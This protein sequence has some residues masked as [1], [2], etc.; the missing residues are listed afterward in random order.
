M[1][2]IARVLFAVWVYVIIT[3]P[4]AFIYWAADQPVCEPLVVESVST[5]AYPVNI[6]TSF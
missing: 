6:T 5:D 1:R 3:Y 2:K 4:I